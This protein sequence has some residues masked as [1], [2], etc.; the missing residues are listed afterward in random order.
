MLMQRSE[1]LGLFVYDAEENQIL[2]M[3][4][5]R[6]EDIYR[7]QEGLTV[8]SYDLSSQPFLL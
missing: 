1:D 3:H 8:I 2:L 6:A 7:R 4:H 5:I